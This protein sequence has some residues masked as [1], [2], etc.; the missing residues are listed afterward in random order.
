VRHPDV[1]AEFFEDMWKSLKAGTL[2]GVVKNRCKNGDYYWLLNNVA[3]FYENDQL[4]GYM[5]VRLKASPEQIEAAND[6]YQLFRD[7]KAGN[8]KIQDAKSSNRP[9]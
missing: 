5:S 1:P 9:Y 2:D 6:V 7:G 4:V 3:P 8:L